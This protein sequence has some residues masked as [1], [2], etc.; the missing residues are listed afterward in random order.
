M[1]REAHPLSVFI[2]PFRGV[3]GCAE[4]PT[5]LRR[6]HVIMKRLSGIIAAVSTA[7]LCIDEFVTLIKDVCDCIA[8][9]NVISAFHHIFG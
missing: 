2:K 6:R 9:T 8:D 3:V 5:T 7:T 4:H 1:G